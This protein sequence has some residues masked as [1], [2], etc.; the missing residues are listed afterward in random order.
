MR[1]LATKTEAKMS[2]QSKSVGFWSKRD[3]RRL[4]KLSESIC[5]QLS[6]VQHPIVGT[7]IFQNDVNE[8]LGAVCTGERSNRSKS[9][10]TLLFTVAKFY[11]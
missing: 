5:R 4:L 1:M 9:C 6:A 8:F 2:S 11:D 7:E 10:H 3:K